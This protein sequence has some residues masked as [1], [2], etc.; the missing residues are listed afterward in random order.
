MPIDTPPGSAGI[1]LQSRSDLA[2]L[3]TAFDA[4]T[5]LVPADRP[6]QTFRSRIRNADVVV[7]RHLLATGSGQATAASIRALTDDGLEVGVRR[8]SPGWWGRWTGGRPQLEAGF[9]DR[10]SAIAAF[11]PIWPNATAMSLLQDIWAEALARTDQWTHW[12]PRMEEA[13]RP[14]DV[15]A[16]KQVLE[17]DKTGLWDGA[18]RYS[19]ITSTD[20]S[21]AGAEADADVLLRI[22][23]P[24]HD[25]LE[26]EPNDMRCYG[27][28]LDMDAHASPLLGLQYQS[29]QHHRPLQSLTDPYRDGLLPL[30]LFDGEQIEEALA[31]YMRCRE[32]LLAQ[33]A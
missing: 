29:S 32:H 25:T 15:Q 6:V 4:V 12:W 30:G 19:L 14:E 21:L 20:S 28:Q 18:S 13:V 24:R 26:H 16:M 27:F 2:A 22:C 3:E 5:E 23:L 1:R 11:R 9:R 17:K 31:L 10:K 33:S 7:S 8:Q